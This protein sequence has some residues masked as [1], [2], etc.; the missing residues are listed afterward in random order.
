M[1]HSLAL[2]ALVM[3]SL[4][5]AA[6]ST[7]AQVQRSFS[8][9]TVHLELSAGAYWITA[10]HEGLIR[11]LPRAKADQM[12]VR[13][14]VSTLGTRANVS[15]RGPKDGFAADIEVPRRVD[16]VVSLTAGALR[17]RGIEGSKEISAESGEIEIELGDRNQYGRVTALVR[18]GA[19]NLPGLRDNQP[20]R[21]S[22]EWTGSGP[23]DLRVRLDAGTITLRD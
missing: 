6:A 3:G 15:V 23:H 14:N 10:S 16:L 4:A 12:S 11:V 22:L 9:E 13:V 2:C 21:R 17:V 18:T 7:A 8:G 19:V 5:A 20:A 1:R